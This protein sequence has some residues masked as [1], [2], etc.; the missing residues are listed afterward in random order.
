MRR[1]FMSV[2]HKDISMMYFLVSVWGGLVGFG[3]SGLI[4][5]ELSVSGSWLGSEALYN[6]LVTSHA[7]MMVFFL[8]MPLFMGGLGNLLT[9][10]MM[11]LS[12]MV[13]PRLNNM[14]VLMVYASLGMFCFSMTQSGPQAG[15]T[16]YP[17]LS[18]GV[19]MGDSSVDLSILS[20]HVLGVSSILN[21][22]NILSSV[23][24]SWSEGL[25]YLEQISLMV[26]S[27][28]VTSV[29]VVVT[30]P[31]LAAALAMLLLDRSTNSSFFDPS[32]S[33][34]LILYQ[35]LF[36]FFGHP[37]VY[38]LILPGFGVV[39]HVVVA[40]SGKFEVFGYMGMVY[41]L[42]SIG[43]LGLVVWAHHMFTVGLDVDT[44]AYFT[45]ASMTIAIPT[46][47]KIFSWVA[48]MFGVSNKTD[49]AILWV[50]G[51]I[52]MFVIGGVT[53]IMLASSSLDVVLH[54]TYFVVAHFHYV[55]SMGVVFSLYL[56]LGYWS[57]LLWGVFL[58]DWLMKVHFLLTFVSVN[59]I[60]GAQFLLG[61]LNMP[62]RYVDFP[63]GM[64]F[65]NA[66]SSFGYMLS[67]ISVILYLGLVGVALMS[68]SFSSN[69]SVGLGSL[70]AGSFSEEFHKPSEALVVVVVG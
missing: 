65:F 14:S 59:L 61:M 68:G 34:G 52:F 1:W 28:C 46:G 44:R 13:F 43:L 37:E 7:V 64:E 17:P 15:W 4:R 47:I 30:V 33:G 6:L 38:I 36:W 51:F 67:F 3:L 22:L 49:S 2:N 57:Y 32:G 35:H 16:Y 62:R 66:V 40:Y 45:A 60:F 26:W 31:V 48:T 24:F 12:D 29:L 58:K 27:L 70:E 11:G 9:P 69:M 39:S 55:L 23:L 18:G 21:S 8:V 25:V 42:V 53:G 50:S 41:A 63:D 5:V 56:A 19:F 10:M 20:L 54:D